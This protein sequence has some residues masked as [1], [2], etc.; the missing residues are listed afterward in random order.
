VSSFALVAE[1]WGFISINPRVKSQLVQF[2][3]DPIKLA[4]RLPL[5]GNLGKYRRYRDRGRRRRRRKTKGRASRQGGGRGVLYARVVDGVCAQVVANARRHSVLP[6]YK[7]L[8]IRG[9][10]RGRRRRACDGR[11][12]LSGAMEH[13]RAIT[14]WSFYR[15]TLRPANKKGHTARA[16]S[17]RRALA[18]IMKRSAS[19][20]SFISPGSPDASCQ[21]DRDRCGTGDERRM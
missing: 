19:R 8:G 18:A 16:I 1:T 13:D 5:Y 7:S 3:S 6:R 10:R 21:R 11:D 17:D 20:G 4:H 2:R 14:P 12:N 15:R 9:E